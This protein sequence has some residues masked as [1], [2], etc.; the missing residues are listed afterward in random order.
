[1]VNFS[2]ILKT[3]QGKICV[4]CA[5]IAVLGL[6]GGLTSDAGPSSGLGAFVVFLAIAVVFFFKG[7]KALANPPTANATATAAV[8]PTAPQSNTFKPGKKVGKYFQLDDINK[9]WKAPTTKSKRVHD[10]SELVDYSLIE[11]G[12]SITSG[13]LGRAIAGGLAFGGLGAVLGGMTGKQKATCSK[14]QIML[15]VNDIK[16]PTLF[17]DLLTY[18]VKKD[19]SVYKMYIEQAQEIIALLGI[20]KASNN[21]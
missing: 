9:K 10:Y 1:M 20:I 2:D 18:E 6:I 11:D 14:L 17:I 19:S 3:K 16:Q 5:V 8:A 4:V 13:S 7:K 12:N 21:Q 15:T